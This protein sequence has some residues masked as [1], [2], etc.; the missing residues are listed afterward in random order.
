MTL[1]EVTLALTLVGVVVTAGY[2]LYETARTI[3]ERVD[4]S[5]SALAVESAVRA[6]ISSWLQHPVMLTEQL[7]FYAFDQ[8]WQGVDDDRLVLWVRDPLPG[9]PGLARLQLS[10]DR[11]EATAEEG[12]VATVVPLSDPRPRTIMMAPTVGRLNLAFRTPNITD[13]LGSWQS[14]SLTPRE[15]V[16]ELGPRPGMRLPPLLARPWTVVVGEAR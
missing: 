1:V 10:V 11:D 9:V 3:H 15:I 16:I 6:T 7:G 13:D 5:L 8:S 14:Q 2:Q 4:S 12:L